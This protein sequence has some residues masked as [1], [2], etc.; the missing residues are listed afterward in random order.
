MT[1]V[2]RWPFLLGV[3]VLGLV[4]PLQAS[5][6]QVYVGYAD[7]LRASPFFPT[8]WGGDPSVDLFAA[9]GTFD[10][11]AV[12]IHNDGVS[13]I[14]INN[15]FVTIN[16]S[17]GAVGFGIWGGSLPAV[18][19]AGKDAIF[20]QTF[21]FNFDTSDFPIVPASL[22][23]N[24][25]VGALSTSVLCTSNAPS[26]DVTVDTVLA[27]FRD[28]GHVLNTGGFDA[29]C[30]LPDGNESLQWRLIGTTG[31]ENPGGAA[32]PEPASLL[33]F[34]SGLAGL[35]AWRMRKKV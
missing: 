4:L 26:V 22:V 10:A 7:N 6:Y 13:A 1:N 30:C 8:P 35:A 21:S 34:G 5:A 20:S 19:G 17:A 2:K 18:I 32:V 31:V 25:S 24:C 14:T 12:R 11:G 15:L 27:N 3:L 29:V 33:L 23:N 16:P 9:G 28:T